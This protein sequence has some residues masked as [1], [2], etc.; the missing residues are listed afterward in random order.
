MKKSS[1]SKSKHSFKLIHKKLLKGCALFSIFTAGYFS[2]PFLVGGANKFINTT[3]AT[4]IAEKSEETNPDYLEVCFTPNQSCLPSI[5]KSI[6]DAKVSILLLGYSFTSQPI[7]NAL[8]SAKKRGVKV[9]IVLDHSQLSQK[10]SKESVDAILK[11]QIEV[12]FDHS[13]KIAH[14]KVLIIDGAQTITGSYNWS[15]SADKKNAENLVFIG[16]KS[17]SKQY[18]DYFEG[19]W[20]ISTPRTNKIAPANLSRKVAHKQ[21]ARAKIKSKFNVVNVAKKG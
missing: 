7:T 3:P 21:A 13:V 10:S 14:N 12:R 2:Y 15:H 1:T 19:R 9:R 6:E 4:S 18:S 16:S 8:I 5:L 17:V 11:E 20:N